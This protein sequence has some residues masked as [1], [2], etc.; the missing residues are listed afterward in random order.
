MPKQ[1]TL[2]E[3][4]AGLF[5]YDGELCLKTEYINSEG[6]IDAY[7]TASGKRFW[8]KAPYTAENQRAQMVTPAK[9]IEMIFDEEK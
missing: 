1:I 6:L 9:I 2:A 3:L 7:I 5:V 4:R 8:G